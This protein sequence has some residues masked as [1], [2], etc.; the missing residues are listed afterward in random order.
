MGRFRPPSWG[1]SNSRYRR[2]SPLAIRPGEGRLT[3]P[4]A[5]ARLCQP[6]RRPVPQTGHPARREERAAKPVL[7][8]P[9]ISALET[10]HPIHS[11]ARRAP[12]MKSTRIDLRRV[13][14]YRDADD[15][16]PLQRHY[17]HPEHDL[18]AD[19]DIVLAHERQLAVIAATE[20]RQA[21]GE[22]LL[23]RRRSAH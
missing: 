13:L 14:R 18:V 7:K 2:L 19:I 11:T 20:N 12:R 23:L 4:T 17:S 9:I 6:Q 3:E 1:R 16:C 22:G 10:G 15:P 8:D 5:A 21:S